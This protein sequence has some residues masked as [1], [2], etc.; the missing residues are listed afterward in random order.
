MRTLKNQKGPW[1]SNINKINKIVPLTQPFCLCDKKSPVS[2]HLISHIYMSYELAFIHNNHTGDTFWLVIEKKQL[3]STCLRGIIL[4]DKHFIGQ[5]GQQ[6]II[7]HCYDIDCILSLADLLG[8]GLSIMVFALWNLRLTK[9]FHF[10]H[11][12][13]FHISSLF[14]HLFHMILDCFKKYICTRINC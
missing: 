3:L 1:A 10:G 9:S 14:L 11:V 7:L 12:N 4:L 8:R 6:Y 5:H 13:I 2:T